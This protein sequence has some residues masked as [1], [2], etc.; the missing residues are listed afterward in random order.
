MSAS[1]IESLQRNPYRK[2]DEGSAALARFDSKR[3][4]R[5]DRSGRKSLFR[6]QFECPPEPRSLYD[7]GR[8]LKRKRSPSTV[9]VS[10]PSKALGLRLPDLRGKIAGEPILIELSEDEPSR[11]RGPARRLLGVRL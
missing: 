1:A 8:E 2:R 10:L 5:G 6:D 7:T 11:E 4:T 3:R 9:G